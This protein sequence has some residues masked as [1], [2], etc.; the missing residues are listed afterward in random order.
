MTA[1]DIQEIAHR[2]TSEDEALSVASQ[3]SDEF[4]AGAGVR[5][6]QRLLPHDEVRTL[7]QSGLLGLSV[8]KEFGGIDAST[9]TL[10]E[11]FRLLA[12]GDPSIAQIPHSHFTFLEALRYQG[13]NEQKQFFYAEALSGKQFA[14][15]QSERGNKTIDI[16]GTTLTP[17]GEDFVLEGRKF[18]CTGALFAD[19]IVVRAANADQFTET[20]AQVKSAVYLPRSTPGLSIVDDW[21]GMG[22][23]TTASGTVTLESVSVPRFNVVPFTSLFTHPTTYGAQ[24]QI[25]HAAIDTGIASAALRESVKLAAKARPFF[26][27]KVD[28]AVEDPLLVQLAGEAAIEVRAARSL[29]AEAARSIDV[30]RFSPTEDSTARA[31][32]DAATAK[33]VGAR[34]SLAATSTLFEIG[35]TRSAGESANLSRFWRDA[36][37]HT[38]HDPTRWKVQHIG[39]WTLSGTIPPRHGLL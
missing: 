13:S 35:G 28:T 26:E 15:A 31:S 3:L 21:D 37:T 8:P 22:Q 27:A 32:I 20:G 10:A 2:I 17:D 6:A 12:E 34:A 29:L 14:N 19:W 24:A 1:V 23:K 36:R 9:E 39:R 25:L 30:A 4:A 11:V 7:A 38:L 18:Y 33:V 5:D 16:D